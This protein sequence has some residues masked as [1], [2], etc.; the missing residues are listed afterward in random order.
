[1]ANTNTE[2]GELEIVAFAESKAMNVHIFERRGLQ[3][4]RIRRVLCGTASEDTVHLL[5]VSRCHNDLLV[6]GQLERKQKTLARLA[7]EPV[8]EQSNALAR[9]A[10][11]TETQPRHTPL[12]PAA[13]GV[14]TTSRGKAPRHL[15]PYTPSTEQMP[16]QS[17]Q[18]SVGQSA[19][20]SSSPR[21]GVISTASFR[22]RGGLRDGMRVTP[23]SR[24]GRSCRK[25]LRYSFGS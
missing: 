22:A 19:C 8:C 2:G 7:A 1:M 11:D 20:W 9:F 14:G 5:N 21:G 18:L 10:E 17:A 16:T 24:S 23:R 6:G 4:H 3:F 13:G 25:P 15:G 12:R